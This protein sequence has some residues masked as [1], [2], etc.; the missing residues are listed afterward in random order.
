M[1]HSFAHSIHSVIQSFISIHGSA[2]VEG[3]Q[4]EGEKESEIEASED[5]K[6]DLDGA[7][8]CVRR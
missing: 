1:N 2:A 6:S 3:E 8:K 7:R 4:T 5:Q